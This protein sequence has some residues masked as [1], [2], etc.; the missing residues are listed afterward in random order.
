[1][2]IARFPQDVR[3]VT[4]LPGDFRPEPLGDRGALIESIRAVAPDVDFSDPHRGRLDRESFVMVVCLDKSDPVDT[5]MLTVRG[6][7]EAIALIATILTQL[8]AHAW[9]IQTGELFTVDGAT[10]SIIA[11]RAF[12]DRVISPPA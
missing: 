10:D 8:Q 3:F 1:M 11:W 9:D 6:G 4:D 2:M 12:R 7:T 5:I